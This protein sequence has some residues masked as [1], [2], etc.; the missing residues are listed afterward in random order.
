MQRVSTENTAQLLPL[1]P[2]TEG[3]G[4]FFQP[5]DKAIGNPATSP[6][7]AWF[8]RVQEELVNVIKVFNN[9][10]DEEVKAFL[11]GSD[12]TQLVQA[13]AAAVLSNSPSI[14][15]LSDVDTTGLTL[16]QILKF[17]GTNFIPHSLQLT[18][19]ATLNLAM[20]AFIKANILSTDPAGKQGNVIA[21]DF[22][23]DTLA[24]KTG[25]TYEGE[26]YSTNPG[27]YTSNLCVGGTASAS[28][29]QVGLVASNAF[30]GSTANDPY[31]NPD[32]VIP[33]WLQYTF[34]ASQAIRKVVLYPYGD[35]TITGSIQYWDGSAWQESG[36][37]FSAA[38][39]GA[40]VY[41]V[42]GDS[43]QWRV[44][45][46]SASIPNFSI[47]EVQMMGSNPPNDILLQS[48][49]VQLDAANPT[50]TS[51]YF[52]V[53]DTDTVTD[54]T[55]RVV[56]ISIDGGT[57]FATASY[58]SS[59][60]YEAGKRLVRFDADVSGQAGDQLVWKLET[61]NTKLQKIEHFSA[62]PVNY[63]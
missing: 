45:V 50:D 6:G 20:T 35:H 42:V 18:D 5:G 11:D 27:T 8:N 7:Y 33:C 60:T 56:S 48:T 10:T 52:R 34:T 24:I 2:D 13:I 57:T 9:L 25:A 51:V 38:T 41:P 39:S 62:L 17:D 47:S 3:L 22:K 31:W 15:S 54:G 26:G 46:T 58:T 1:P 23:T 40:V 14:N 12:N 59:W 16:G 19:Q 32:Q 49:S 44:Y 30:D 43:T 28:N 55:D 63:G 29:T 37:V 61:F 21:D 53:T 36:A 4:G